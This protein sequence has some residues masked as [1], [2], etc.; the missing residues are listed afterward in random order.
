[1]PSSNGTILLLICFIKYCLFQLTFIFFIKANQHSA[2]ARGRANPTYLVMPSTETKR[3]KTAWY[4]TVKA[5]IPSAR[6]PPSA[7]PLKCK[8][9]HTLPQARKLYAWP[10][11]KGR[12]LKRRK[13]C[14]R[15]LIADSSSFQ[16]SQNPPPQPQRW[17]TGCRERAQKLK[18]KTKG[19]K[20]LRFPHKQ[21]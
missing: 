1:M 8:L 20:V 5:K 3:L 4:V 14:L 17:K 9:T 15:R 16:K 21:A 13:C 6:L 10:L 7:L 11:R 18:N 2:V 19:A 12:G